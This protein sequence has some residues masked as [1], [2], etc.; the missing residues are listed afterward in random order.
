MDPIEVIIHGILRRLRMTGDYYF[1][2]ICKEFGEIW[3][4]WIY[5]KYLSRQ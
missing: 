2:R 1:C 5:H 3:R 4:I